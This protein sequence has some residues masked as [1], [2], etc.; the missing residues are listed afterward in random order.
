MTDSILSNDKRCFVCGSVINLHRHHIFYGTARR[1]IS[2]ANGCW[3]WL[4]AW[5]HT[6]GRKGVHADKNLD[7]AL[8]TICQRKWEEMKGTRDDFI[9]TFGKSYL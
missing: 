4:C 8:K 1:S 3:V 7:Y 9:R 5:H 6:G 2:E